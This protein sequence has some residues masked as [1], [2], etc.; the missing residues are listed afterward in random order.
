MDVVLISPYSDIAALGVRGISAV[1]KEAGHHTRLIFLPYQFPEIEYRRDFMITYSDTI[2][3][4]VTCLCRGAGIIGISLMTN[5]FEQAATLSTHLR[6]TLGIPLIWGGIHPTISPEHCLDY[7]DYVCV[8]EGEL[9]MRDVVTALETNGDITAIANI[10]SR[11]NDHIVSNPPRPMIE[12]LDSLPYFDYD[13]DDHH[14]LDQDTERIVPLDPELL[15][16]YLTKKAPTKGRAALFYQT[17]ASRGCPHNCTY[18]CWHALKRIYDVKT[19]IRRRSV[20]HIIGEL[21]MILDRMPW[22]KEITF[23]DDSFLDAPVAEIEHMATE[24]KRVAHQRPFQCL[25]EPRTI[26]RSR[27]DPL[28]DAGLANIQIGIQSGSERIKEMYR[29][30]HSNQRIIEMGLLLK[31][32]IPRIRP[33]IYDFILDNPWET[34]QDKYETLQLLLKIPPPFYLQIFRLTFFPGT[35]L[36]EKARE[37]G[38]IGND[39]REIYSQQYN[40]RDITYINLLFS[41]FSRPVPRSIM[42]L[43]CSKPAIGLFHNRPVNAVLKMVHGMYRRQMLNQRKKRIDRHKAEMDIGAAHPF[44]D[45]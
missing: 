37:E 7:C 32:Y 12:N 6:Q 31:E 26:T 17:I 30:T 1:L 27:M 36:F 23:S 33:P 9:V 13:M 24:Y 20:N 8:G 45:R 38:L 41:A 29:R 11:H 15:R 5:Y 25:A 2:L 18:C 28:V 22:F 3:D 21:E 34:I 43:A 42:A 16:K 4:Q 19:N 39:I 35:G 40:E 10:T 14:V 44:Q